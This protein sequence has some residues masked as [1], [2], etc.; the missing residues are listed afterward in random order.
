[1][2]GREGIY[3]TL[4]VGVIL[5]LVLSFLCFCRTA[6]WVVPINVAKYIVLGI[7]LNIAAIVFIKRMR[8]FTAIPAYVLLTLL[9]LRLFSAVDTEIRMR[10]YGTLWEAIHTANAE[11]VRRR[12]SHGCNVQEM[13]DG[14]PMICAVFQLYDYR[15][16]Y[17]PAPP[18]RIRDKKIV[19]ILKV[20]I[21]NGANV[22]AV[23]QHRG[24]SAVFW[25]TVQ[26]NPEAV[27]LLVDKGADVN[28]ADK[29]GYTPLHFAQTVETAQVLL[30]AGAE[31][32]AAA[33]DGNT[34]LHMVSEVEIAKL[35]IGHG[36]DVNVENRAHQTPLDS[37]VARG[38]E[39]VAKL[40][41]N[42]GAPSHSRGA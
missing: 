25:A 14:M 2:N 3:S 31:V 20:L 28:L 5:L 42:S 27:R 17:E 40:L 24:W 15:S 29:D 16:T 26:L 10:Y 35:L 7:L 21:E 13:V 37:A 23:D 1:M 33:H 38:D 41:R 19:E 6:F 34:P 32:N 18:K 11:V 8:L 30:R 39:A 4:R 36:A 22:N 9:V 12:I